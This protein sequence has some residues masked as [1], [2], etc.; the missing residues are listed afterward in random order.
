MESQPGFD[1]NHELTAW[2]R[3]LSQQ[4]A[5]TPEETRE[6]EG[7]L[8]DAFEAAKHRGLSG[9]AAFA[10]ARLQ[11]GS[12]EGIGEEYSKLNPLRNWSHRV[13]IMV[14]AIVIVS[15]WR[16]I[17]QTL[18]GIA[19]TVWPLGV[20]EL[21][22]FG[23]VFYGVLPGILLWQTV[24][25]RAGSLRALELLLRSR[26]VL[27]GFLILLWTATTFAGVWAIWN[28][29]R[30]DLVLGPG[31]KEQLTL[32]TLFQQH[33]FASLPWFGP[34]AAM[35]L[36]MAP[37]ARQTLSTATVSGLCGRRQAREIL[38]WT[39]L[40]YVFLS[41]CIG[42][43]GSLYYPLM[44]LGHW[45]F[46]MTPFVSQ[47]CSLGLNLAPV[48]AL[49][50]LATRRGPL[51]A[52]TLAAT[53]RP[54]WSPWRI[55]GVGAMAFVIPYGLLGL[56]LSFSPSNLA[57]WVIST[58]VWHALFTVVAARLYAQL[59]VNPRASVPKAD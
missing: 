11:V 5:I 9:K 19:Q 39:A 10:E 50:W 40:G 33:L 30:P 35:L 49:A 47:L 23:V 51:F 54:F 1:L 4:P 53:G 37:K 43:T 18:S 57:V 28:H 16:A 44:R 7:H 29:P 36:V 31:A 45:L 20:W 2:R 59:N 15:H 48:A 41:A 46:D 38:L 26:A 17:G 34:W 42:L 21:L 3:Q 25:G 55:A 22:T 32:A 12:A 6:L 24:H 8:L 27:G 52:A 58:G 14:L 13:S 56:T